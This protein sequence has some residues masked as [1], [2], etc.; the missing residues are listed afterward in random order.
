MLLSPALSPAASFNLTS[1]L[2]NTRGMNERME[3]ERA[4]LAGVSHGQTVIQR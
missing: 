4:V 1:S 2:P 3:M